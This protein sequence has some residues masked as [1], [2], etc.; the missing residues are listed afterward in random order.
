M[1]W[2][3]WKLIIVKSYCV[4]N[5][6][7]IFGKLNIRRNTLGRSQELSTNRWIFV[8]VKKICEVEPLKTFSFPILNCFLIVSL[9]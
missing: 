9:G 3:K 6:P 4:P 7:S 8:S 5:F 2:L 1:Y